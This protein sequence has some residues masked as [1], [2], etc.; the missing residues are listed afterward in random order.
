MDLPRAR[1]QEML[2][3]AIFCTFFFFYGLGAFGLMGA[4]EP[5]YAQV[6]REMLQRNDWV[7]PTL[8]GKVW[9]EKPVLYYWGAMSSYWLF[10]VRDWAARVPSAVLASLMIFAIYLFTRWWRPMAGFSTALIVCS[11]AAIFG[12]AR[13]ASTDMPL[14]ATFTI[15]MLAWFAWWRREERRWLLLFYFF[16]AAAA[17]AKGPVAPGLAGLIIVT[18]ALARWEWK[19]IPRTLW[20]PGV[21]LF[22]ATALPWYLLVQWRNPQFFEEFILQQNF[23]RF[24]TNLYRHE[25]PWWYYAPVLILGLMP[26]TLFAVLALGDALKRWRSRNPTQAEEER[27]ALRHFLVIW[28]VV[29]VLFFSVSHSKLPGYIL[30]AMPA[31]LLLTSNY[32]RDKMESVARLPKLL[33]VAQAAALAILAGGVFLGPRLMHKPVVI[34]VMA[35]RMAGVVALMVFAAVIVLLDVSK[36]E[37]VRF[38]TLLPLVLCVG[39]VLKVAAPVV[40]ATQSARPVARE[41]AS[42]APSADICAGNISRSLEYGLAFYRDHPVYELGQGQSPARKCLLVAP[43][44]R[45]SVLQ[46]PARRLFAGDFPEQ[47]LG[48][49][50]IDLPAQPAHASTPESI[51]PQVNP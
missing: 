34:P 47:S 7:T 2:Y 6:A 10:G 1:L 5:R 16:A 8:Y 23:A 41:L 20:W 3:L 29:P 46:I 37:M 26:W 33:I 45:K 40:D 43:L 11:S 4:D 13:G 49:W 9:L 19:L 36:W 31:W 22:L 21:L 14:A 27:A 25:Y 50:W 51:P 28:A 30:P 44:T 32:L 12:F 24:S 38:A 15:A 18:L 39:F 17:L 35:F 48:F 42:F